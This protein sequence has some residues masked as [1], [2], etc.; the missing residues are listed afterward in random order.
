MPLLI[1]EEHCVEALLGFSS[2]DKT[3]FRFGFLVGKPFWDSR[4]VVYFFVPSR[5]SALSFEALSVA[6]IREE[7]NEVRRL[8]SYLLGGLYIIG[9]FCRC[10]PEQ[11]FAQQMVTLLRTIC[12]P[13]APTPVSRESPPDIDTGFFLHID[14]AT[15]KLAGRALP[16]ADAAGGLALVETKLQRLASGF[17]CARL[18]CSYPVELRVPL[19]AK[20]AAGPMQTALLVEALEGAVEA[21]IGA[22][23]AQTQFAMPSGDPAGSAPAEPLNRPLLTGEAAP[24]DESTPLAKLVPNLFGRGDV[25]VQSLVPLG[26][27]PGPQAPPQQPGTP[28]H[29]LRWAGTLVGCALVH[30]RQSRPACASIRLLRELDAAGQLAPLGAALGGAETVQLPLGRLLLT[31]PSGRPGRDVLA[32]LQSRLGL[33]GAGI[34]AP[35]RPQPAAAGAPLAGAGS[36]RPTHPAREGRASPKPGAEPRPATG[37]SPLLLELAV[38]D[39]SPRPPAADSP[40]PAPAPAPAPA[41]TSSAEAPQ[42]AAEDRAAAKAKR[43][44]QQARVGRV[45][46]AIVAGLAVLFVSGVILLV[47]GP[48]K[49]L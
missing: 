48:A 33:T 13:T 21:H 25:A 12:L 29:T 7:A 9:A 20:G 22:T 18:M 8:K 27:A 23:L 40:L 3:A 45:M 42:G 26:L 11:V 17:Q 36:E 38:D 35:R 41:A 6:A 24:T 19:W 31:C 32:V 2:L 39:E 1:S 37:P 10:P 14:P 15:G 49:P 34:W 47:R 43:D 4:H 46:G 16:L 44:R 30:G 5:T 28:T